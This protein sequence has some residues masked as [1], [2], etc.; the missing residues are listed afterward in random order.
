MIVK[1]LETV[2]VDGFGFRWMVGN[3]G[4]S[5][6][7]DFYDSIWSFILIFVFLDVSTSQKPNLIVNPEFYWVGLQVVIIFIS[8]LGI[9]RFIL[10]CP[11]NW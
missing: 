8:L 1:M 6:I 5:V 2:G 11:C 9:D 3:S 4:I 10:A 7:M